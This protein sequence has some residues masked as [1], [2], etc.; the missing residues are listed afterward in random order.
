MAVSSLDFPRHLTAASVDAVGYGWAY[1]SI[2]NRPVP[3][4]ALVAQD[5]NELAKAFEMFGSWAK[6]TDSDSVELTFVFRKAGGY[7]LAISAEPTRLQERCLRFNRTHRPVTFGATW[8]KPIDTVNPF[9]LQFR[10]YRS[11]AIAP[12]LFD[13]V[14]YGKPRAIVGPPSSPNFNPISGLSPLLKFEA[15]FVDEES[16]T[17]DSLAWFALNSGS[18][19]IPKSVSKPPKPQPREIARRRVEMLSCHFPVTLERMRKSQDARNLIR[20]AAEEGV[21]AWQV[22]QALCNI[23]L[24]RGFGGESAFAGLSDR[25]AEEAFDSALNSRFELASGENASAAVTEEELRQQVIADGR[26]LLNFLKQDSADNLSAIQAALRST[27]SLE[28]EP[29]I[30]DFRTEGTGTQ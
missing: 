14:A 27:E 24:S 13:G 9:L 10:K 22:E 2:V 1:S 26:A 15:T 16:A 6:A 5:G 11:A 4:I 8:L 28:G 21:R 18:R 20:R 29:V 12:F 30:A 19:P 3:S 23:A 17:P 7:V 25:K